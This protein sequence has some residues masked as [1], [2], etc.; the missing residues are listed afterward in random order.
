MKALFQ[1][2]ISQLGIGIATPI[3]GLVLNAFWK[4]SSSYIHVC[5]YIFASRVTKHGAVTGFEY[6]GRWSTIYIIDK[7]SIAVDEWSEER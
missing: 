2:M 6:R 1:N 7:W 4:K 5:I 3:C